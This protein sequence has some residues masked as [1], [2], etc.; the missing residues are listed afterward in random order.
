MDKRG[1]QQ[2]Q[3]KVERLSI[4]ECLRRQD[5]RFSP[6]KQ[7]ISDKPQRVRVSE[8][9]CFSH[10]IINDKACENKVA[11]PTDSFSEEE[12]KA[13][14]DQLLD[15]VLVKEKCKNQSKVQTIHHKV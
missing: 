12:R 10:S 5:G 1:Q 4:Q 2:T 11:S 8:D 6:G 3:P 14:V 13:E 7:H 9:A 15:K